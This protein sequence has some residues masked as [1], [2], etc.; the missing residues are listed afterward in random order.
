MLCWTQCQQQSANYELLGKRQCC[1]F[2]G[3]FCYQLQLS[4]DSITTSK[5][6]IGLTT[7]TTSRVNENYLENFFSQH[8]WLDGR[9]DHPIPTEVKNRFRLLLIAKISVDLNSSNVRRDD[10]DGRDLDDVD[11]ADDYLSVQLLYNSDGRDLDDV[12]VADYYLSVQL[13]YN[14]DGRDLDDV[15]VADGYL[16]VQLLYNSDVNAVD[17]SFRNSVSTID[18]CPSLT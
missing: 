5:S 13:L 16:S 4:K 7:Y 6:S 3:D 15:D 1:H 10:S 2:K 18:D 14:S 17:D 9:Y 11:V 12:D 8:R